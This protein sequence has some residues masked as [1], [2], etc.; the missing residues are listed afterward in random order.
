MKNAIARAATRHR[1]WDI[2]RFVAYLPSFA[3]LFFALLVDPRVS[4][5]A[6]GLLIGATVYAVTP[7]DFIPDIV[8]VL[9]EMDDLAIFLTGCR[10]FIQMCP[11]HVVDEHVARIDVSGKWNPFNRA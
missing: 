9:G 7:M 2:F 10:M 6:K 5:W 4:L 1:P 3:K 11:A 8:P